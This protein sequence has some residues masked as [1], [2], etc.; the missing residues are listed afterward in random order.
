MALKKKKAKTAIT[1]RNT[2]QLAEVIDKTKKKVATHVPKVS[3]RDK[4]TAAKN[5]SLFKTALKDIRKANKRHDYSDQ[6][7]IVVY[8][9]LLEMVLDLIPI[10]ESNYRQFKVDRSAYAL[11]TYINQAREITNDIRAIKDFSEQLELI[12]RIVRKQFTQIVQQLVEETFLL[13]KELVDSLGAPSRRIVENK[14][15]SLIKSHGKYM[16]ESVKMIDAQLTSLLLEQEP[17][18]KRRKSGTTVKRGG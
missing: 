5:A 12:N 14:I 16:N 13:K 4:L 6:A 15:E 1:T 10:A 2:K 7:L 8:K 3:A 9:A 17:V 11:N 18:H